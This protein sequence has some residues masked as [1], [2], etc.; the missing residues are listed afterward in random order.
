MQKFRPTDGEIS[1]PNLPLK[2]M[3]DADNN[4]FGETATDVA[5][6]WVL[7][8]FT[9]YDRIFKTI[10]IVLYNNNICSDITFCQ[11]VI[12][13]TSEAKIYIIDEQGKELAILDLKYSFC[14]SVGMY[15][16]F[17]TLCILLRFQTILWY[18]ETESQRPLS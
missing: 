4:T 1:S 17:S 8:E 16:Q 5:D 2:Y 11:L 6:G 13:R 15:V 18:R 7:F 12:N 10:T 14:V 9:K 3:F